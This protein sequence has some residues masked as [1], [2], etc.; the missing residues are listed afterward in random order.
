MGLLNRHIQYIKF[1][2]FTLVN[3][4]FN[5]LGNALTF[6][7]FQNTAASVKNSSLPKVIILEFAVQHVINTYAYGTPADILSTPIWKGS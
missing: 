6:L 4:C 7:V 2:I 1:I 5:A 3:F